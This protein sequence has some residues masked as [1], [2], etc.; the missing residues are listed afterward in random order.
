VEKKPNTNVVA[1]LINDRLV[2]LG[3][4][5]NEIAKR[6]NIHETTFSAIRTGRRRPSREIAEAIAKALTENP[7]EEEQEVNHFLVAAGF[8][9]SMF[10]KK[11]A[12]VIELLTQ[13]ALLEE[14]SKMERGQQVWVFCP[15]LIEIFQKKFFNVVCRNLGKGVS[16]TYFIHRNNHLHW[17]MLHN[18][19]QQ[20]KVL[21]K[22]E[23]LNGFVL[24]EESFRSEDLNFFEC[25]YRAESD[26]LFR[27]FRTS[28]EIQDDYMYREEKR[29]DAVEMRNYLKR[30]KE[31]AKD[32][33]DPP[34]TIENYWKTFG[35][36][37]EKMMK[38]SLRKNS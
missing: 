28:R 21:S 25:I 8:V 34:C 9:P 26:Q 17:G 3:L 11:R 37:F 29:Q 7:E 33:Q 35:K 2:K 20:N 4:K 6:A 38:G 14:E 13:E 27:V 36:D 22:P 24:S 16:Y 15:G 12:V 31:V 1:D 5:A 32:K 23:Q 10:A 18:Q 19:L 30:M